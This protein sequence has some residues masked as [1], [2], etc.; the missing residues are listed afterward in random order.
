V[1]DQRLDKLQGKEPGVQVGE[2]RFP[3]HGMPRAR[4]L[5]AG[6]EQPGL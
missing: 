1:V 2:E 5:L 3:R 6:Q 4:R